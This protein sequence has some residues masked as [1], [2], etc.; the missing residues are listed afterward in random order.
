MPLPEEQQHIEAK[1]ARARTAEA[2]DISP[3]LPFRLEP[4]PAEVNS[5]GDDGDSEGSDDRGSLGS[6]FSGL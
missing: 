4:A 2:L 1:L 6:A 3:P 5:I